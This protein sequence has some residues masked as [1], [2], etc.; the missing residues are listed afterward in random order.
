[1]YLR[2]VIYMQRET[3]SQPQTDDDWWALVEQHK[4]SAELLISE[5]MTANQGYYHVG[6]AV[7]AALKAYICKQKFLNQWP[8]RAVARQLYTHNLFKLFQ[9]SGIE[10]DEH[11]E[12]APSWA[13]VLHWQRL[14][15]YNHERMPRKV[16]Q[17]FYEAAFGNYGVVEWLRTN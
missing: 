1:M 2:S 12:F 7:E 3:P 13:T 10:V 14:Q 15:G 8:V 4:R 9:I 16:A 6:S 11:S 5:E 17:S